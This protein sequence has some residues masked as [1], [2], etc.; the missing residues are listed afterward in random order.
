LL[1]LI[2]RTRYQGLPLPVVKRITRQ[3][4]IGLDYL[5]QLAI[6]HT[7]LKPENALVVMDPLEAFQN[8]S[9]MTVTEKQSKQES[10]GTKAVKMTKNQRR[11]L[12][13]KQQGDGDESQTTNPEEVS[14]PRSGG[15][16]PIPENQAEA[17]NTAVSTEAGTTTT[18]SSQS[19][20]DVPLI[21]NQSRKGRAP[22]PSDP[23]CYNVKI[24]DFGNACWVHK[25]FTSDIQTRQYRSLEAIMGARYS[26]PVDMWSMACMVFELATGDLLFDPRSG[27]HFD[28]TDDHLAQ[29]IETLGPIPKTIVARGKH[30]RDFFNRQ[31]KLKHIHQLHTWPLEDVLK[32]KYRF[33]KEEADAFGAFLRPMLDYDPQTRATA[34]ECLKHPWLE[35]IIDN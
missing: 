21:G 7:D 9:K 26:T 34:K 8:A 16:A 12:R 3:V 19:D 13:L 5:H 28:K 14:S 32:E 2:K 29:F 22:L 24:V 10:G 33:P 23:S 18:V 15:E 11:K 20:S 25:H 31:G 27:K 35:G 30:S 4:L 6:I 1:D 17:K